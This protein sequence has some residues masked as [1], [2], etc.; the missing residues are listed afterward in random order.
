MPA[1]AD[2]ANQPRATTR[3]ILDAAVEVFSREGL[4]ASTREIAR[5]AGVNEATLF[6]Q[7][8]SKD[9]LLTAVTRQVVDL[10]LRALARV[11][12]EDFNLRRDLTRLAKAYRRATTKY[13]AFIRTM[14]AQPAHPKLAQQIMR[15]VIEPLRAKYIAYLAE[16]QRRGLVRRIDL[17][18]AVDAFTGM[19]FAGVLRCSIYRLGYSHQ[20]YLNTCIE[21]F[22]AGIQ[23]SS[24]PA[25]RQS[26]G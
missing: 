17:A 1:A 11:D 23:S 8:E 16:G 13:Q 18:P 3:R 10:Q 14:M 21:V 25:R 6:R 24:C 9:H 20:T 7:F 5:V 4:A 2:S 15:E 22:L 19:I 12:F 26:A